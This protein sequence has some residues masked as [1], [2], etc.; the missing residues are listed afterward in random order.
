MFYLIRQEDFNKN[1]PLPSS[2]RKVARLAVTEGAFYNKKPP[3]FNG[4]FFVVFVSL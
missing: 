3:V 1:P 2:G 4:R